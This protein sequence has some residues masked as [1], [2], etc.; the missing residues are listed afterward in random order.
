MR[1][2]LLLTDLGAEVGGLRRRRATRTYPAD[3]T[4]SAEQRDLRR[5]MFAAQNESIPPMRPG[6]KFVDANTAAADVIGSELKPAS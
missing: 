6:H 4:F 3:G 5:R 2:G 1:D